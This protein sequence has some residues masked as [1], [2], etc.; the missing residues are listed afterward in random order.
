MARGLGDVNHPAGSRSRAHGKGSGGFQPEM[1]FSVL[2]A[3]GMSLVAAN[4]VVFVMGVARILSGGC[5][6]LAKKS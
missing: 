5:T 2:G 4:V 1:H 6:F 3:Q